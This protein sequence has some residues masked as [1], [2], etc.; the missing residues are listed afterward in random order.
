[1]DEFVMKVVEFANF[2]RHVCKFDAFIHTLFVLH[3]PCIITQNQGP[4]T[5]AV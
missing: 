3:Q 1:M 2:T 4:V 5:K